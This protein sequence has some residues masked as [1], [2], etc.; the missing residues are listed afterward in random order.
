MPPASVHL[1]RTA[2]LIASRYYYDVFRGSDKVVDNQR[3]VVSPVSGQT[4]RLQ[5]TTATLDTQ[6]R[7]RV[8]VRA[9]TGQ[10]AVYNDTEASSNQAGV[11]EQ[12]CL[13]L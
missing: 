12:I 13:C 3:A 10:G 11:G 4:D 1:S 6:W 9:T 8:V 2:P 7:Y 5:F